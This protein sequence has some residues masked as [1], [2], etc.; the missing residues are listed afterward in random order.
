MAKDK[1]D[2]QNQKADKK[3]QQRENGTANNDAGKAND[4]SRIKP[5]NNPQPM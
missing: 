4:M 5:N 2:R 3:K 1:K